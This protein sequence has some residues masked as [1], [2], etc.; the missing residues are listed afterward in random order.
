MPKASDI[1]KGDVIDV[2]GR[3][4]V[5]KHID[6]KSPSSRG[7]ATLYKFRVSAVQGG[8][9]L[10]LSHKGDENLSAADVLRRQCQF[11]YQ[12]ADGYT[13]MDNEDY[14]QYTL[15]AEALDELTGYLVDGLEDIYA[16]LIDGVI[17][18]VELPQTVVLEI[19]D[20]APS[21]KGAT[22]TG[23]TKP[24]VLSTGLEIQ[25]PEYL[26]NGDRVKVNTVSGKFMSRAQ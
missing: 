23:R 20:T 15:S 13:F 4:F 17:A 19:T 22:A 7:A 2:D 26:A 1:K 3:P 10:Q 8:Q 12:D 5:V 18:A 24:A 16:L 6:V 14:S 11:L 25:V 21:I 9:T